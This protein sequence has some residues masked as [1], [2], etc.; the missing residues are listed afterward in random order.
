MAEN[1]NKESNPLPTEGNETDFPPL[2]KRARPQ[3]LAVRTTPTIISSRVRQSSRLIQD[4]EKKK[5]MVEED[6]SHSSFIAINTVGPYSTNQ[7]PS[8]YKRKMGSTKRS[9]ASDI[10]QE[11]VT[12]PNSDTFFAASSE[13]RLVSPMKKSKMM[14]YREPPLLKSLDSDTL[15][16]LSGHPS[17]SDSILSDGENSQSTISPSTST[18]AYENNNLG[19]LSDFIQQYS[20]TTLNSLPSDVDSPSRDAPGLLAGVHAISP[21]A[22]PSSSTELSQASLAKSAQPAKSTVQCNPA[23]ATGSDNGENLSLPTSKKDIV[24]TVATQSSAILSSEKSPQILS[25]S[26]DD[27]SAAK[28]TLSVYSPERA[29]NH[30]L[31][32]SDREIY[33]AGQ[34]IDIKKRVCKKN[35]G[36][37]SFYLP[38]ELKV[39]SL[40][41]VR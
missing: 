36:H 39:S 2:P 14:C 32:T 3:A 4:S 6:I 35:P 31:S 19:S 16:F 12:Q 15:G 21:L 27:P 5:E 24:A 34:P 25:E 40:K 13:F 8:P 38:S 9:K 7:T 20:G 10:V 22:L 37:K 33:E 1:V 18:P 41:H 23:D 11:N 17:F 30:S 28:F 29:L 26:K